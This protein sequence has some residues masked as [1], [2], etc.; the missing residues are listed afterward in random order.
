LGL[1]NAKKTI[2]YSFFNILAFRLGSQTAKTSSICLPL[3]P[4]V[5]DPLPLNQNPNSCMPPPRRFFKNLCKFGPDPKKQGFA[6][7]YIIALLLLLLWVAPSQQRRLAITLEII[8]I[9]WWINQ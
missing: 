9:I 8:L 1:Q 5:A 2:A 3:V 4:L 7:L 6:Q